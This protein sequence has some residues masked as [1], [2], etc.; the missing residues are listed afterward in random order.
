MKKS[1]IV[2]LMACTEIMF[3]QSKIAADSLKSEF[4]PY[5]LTTKNALVSSTSSVKGEKLRS[6]PSTNLIQSLY[7]QLPGVFIN[8]TTGEPGEENNE[9]FIRGKASLLEN[10]P[11]ILVDGVETSYHQ[12]HWSEVD[13]VTVLKD[14]ASLAIY[15]LRGA[16]GVLLIN[17]IRGGVTG[18]PSVNFNMRYGSQ[19][20]MLF[21]L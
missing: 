20:P 1:I 4:I 17:T 7:G 5:G 2:L 9:I 6:M 21:T 11:L 8:Q 15:G 16:N 12:I 13:K 18:K 19:Q 14:A 3:G 10:I